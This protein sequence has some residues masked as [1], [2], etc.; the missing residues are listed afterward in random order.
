MDKALKEALARAKPAPMDEDV[1]LRALFY[2]DFSAGKTDLCLKTF[3]ALGCNR[4]GFITSDSAWTTALKYPEIADRLDRFTFEGITQVKAFIE[5]RK[6]G[7]EPYASWDCFIWDT[8]STSADIVTGNLVEGKKFNDQIDPDAPSWTH[9][10]LTKRFVR[11]AV[12]ELS[13][14]DMHIL[15]TTHT[16]YPTVQDK[17]EAKL[18]I[19]PNM[20]EETYKIVAQE[21]QL[22]GW[23]HKAKV[24]GHRVVQTEMTN[25]VTAKT[26]IQT[27]PE[28]I[29][30]V[31][32]IPNMIKEW[33][34]R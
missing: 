29:H 20:P 10:N 28:G 3:D 30:R 5:A 18:L 17:K 31:E 7:I 6:E 13:K 9:Y 25:T 27:I 8:I 12:T 16:R 26:H 2:G 4:G 23:L 15:Y 32:L 24:G 34:K 19:R 22:I 21:V 14:T 1:K 11:Q 33:T